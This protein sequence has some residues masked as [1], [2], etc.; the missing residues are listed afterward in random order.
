MGTE[1]GFAYATGDKPV[2]GGR[3]EHAG[4]HYPVGRYRYSSF[5]R[6]AGNIWLSKFAVPVYSSVFYV[7][8]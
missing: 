8:L 2:R 1:L 7:V 5:H 6:L 4:S 3:A